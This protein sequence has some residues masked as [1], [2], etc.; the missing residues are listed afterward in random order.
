M[1]KNFLLIA[2]FSM[3]LVLTSGCTKYSYD[4]EID[5]NENVKVSE[6]IAI[7]KKAQNAINQYQDQSFEKQLKIV[8]ENAKN[9]SYD[10][11]VIRGEDFDGIVKSRPVVKIKQLT[12]EYFP[13]GFSSDNR[14]PVVIEKTSFFKKYKISLKY[15]FEDTQRINKS[16]ARTLELDQAGIEKE[17]TEEQAVKKPRINL[18][19]GVQENTEESEEESDKRIEDFASYLEIVSK[20]LLEDMPISQLTIKVPVKPSIQNATRA[21]SDLEY[22]WDLVSSEPVYIQLEY[23]IPNIPGIIAILILASI[24][25]FMFYFHAKYGTR[26]DYSDL[27]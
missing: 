9:S 6:T 16:I 24:I 14:A 12:K 15:S 5:K 25:G 26:G 27:Q 2:L 22:Q 18:I 11:K 20:D 17:Q 21:L 3:V 7:S 1:K 19:T 4:I 13:T 10:V 23:K 8:E